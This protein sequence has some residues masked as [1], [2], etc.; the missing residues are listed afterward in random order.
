MV[1]YKPVIFSRQDLGKSTVTAVWQ[2][3]TANWQLAIFPVAIDSERDTKCH[4]NIFW[5][6]SSRAF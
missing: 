4:S 2:V 3:A 1:Q 6:T 5:S